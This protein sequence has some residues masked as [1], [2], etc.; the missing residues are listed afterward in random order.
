MGGY[1]CVG[2]VNL[3]PLCL[4]LSASKEPQAYPVGQHRTGAAGETPTETLDVTSVVVATCRSLLSLGV[5]WTSVELRRGTERTGCHWL[6]RTLSWASHPWVFCLFVCLFVL[7]LVL[8]SWEWNPGSY[9]LGKDSSTKLHPNQPF[10]FSCF[11][12][13]F[14]LYR[15]VHTPALHAVVTGQPEGLSSLLPRGWLPGTDLRSPISA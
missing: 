10:L 9:V 12:L 2:S 1:G 8:R 5:T 7:F 4:N 11:V 13:I 15:C 6:L 14:L 3:F